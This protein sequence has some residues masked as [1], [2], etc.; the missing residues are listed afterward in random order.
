[1]DMK[2]MLAL[3]LAAALL[4]A[5]LSGCV[6]KAAA[7]TT[8][9]LTAGVKAD[10][11]EAGALTDADAAAMTG[12][13]VRLLQKTDAGKTRLLSPVSVLYALGMTANGAGGETKTQLEQAFGLS[14]D[15]LNRAALAWRTA[16]A[17]GP[18]QLA[19]SVWLRDSGELQVK[20]NF[21]RTDVA[22]YDAEVYKAAFDGSTLNA[23]NAWVKEHTDGMI[24]SIL[25][26]M[27]DGAMLFLINAVA[28]DDKWQTPYEPEQVSD[29]VFT[30]ADG[31]A[32]TVTMMQSSE[33]KYL[34]D[35]QAEGFIRYYKEGGYAFAALLPDEGV[36][37]D[38]Y[39]AS[40]TGAGLRETLQNAAE[41]EV[42]VTLPKF[43][44][45]YSAEL[46]DSLKALGVTDAFDGDRAD[47]SAMGQSGEGR[48]FLS[49][50]LH[51]THIEVDEQGTKAAAVTAA[52]MTATACAPDDQPKSVVLDR[53][54]V[55]MILDTNTMLPVFLGA[56]Y[57]IANS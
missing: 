49:R 35:G 28:F 19:D 1:M 4:A 33:T 20:E 31:T 5:A 22:Y 46:S 55:Y 17:D 44:S 45:D 54:F 50:V 30:A 52:V 29:G 8:S 6:Q 36:S 39:I 24:P 42:D 43:S 23:V 13:G 34:E 3:L 48:L 14:A 40:L 21:L 26:E 32:R 27:P 11:P 37:I 41:T 38:D 53:P 10:A 57:D 15:E 12:F 18:L 47:F 51:K 25:D 56:V 16:A 2:K 7:V 9:E